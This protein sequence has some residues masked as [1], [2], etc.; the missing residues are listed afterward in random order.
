MNNWHRAKECLKQKKQCI[1]SP[2]IRKKAHVAWWAS[3]K[4]AEGEIKEV[5]GTQKEPKLNQV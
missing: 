2:L 3:Y 4:V 1:G 5:E